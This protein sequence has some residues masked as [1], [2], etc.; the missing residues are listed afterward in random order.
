MES[1]SRTFQLNSFLYWNLDI[2][3]LRFMFNFW[4]S[5]TAFVN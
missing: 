4:I 2:I 1:K 5:L 3:F